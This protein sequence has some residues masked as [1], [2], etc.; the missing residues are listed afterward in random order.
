MSQAKFSFTDEGVTVRPKC[1]VVALVCPVAVTSAGLVGLQAL[2]C[3]AAGSN[4]TALNCCVSLR[5]L[6]G[7]RDGDRASPLKS[8][9]AIANNTKHKF[10]VS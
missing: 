6:L 3:H 2:L 8:A 10:N 4:C 9:L 1:M 7:K 5:L